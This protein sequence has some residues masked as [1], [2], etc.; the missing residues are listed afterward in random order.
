M[1]VTPGPWVELLVVPMSYPSAGEAI[2][3]HRES[4]MGLC[5]QIIII[6]MMMCVLLFLQSPCGCDMK[7]L[8]VQ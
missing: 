7:P 2:H 5:P 1:M 4:E 8:C 6:I 3:S